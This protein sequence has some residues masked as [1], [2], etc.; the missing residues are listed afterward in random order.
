M[1]ADQ[2]SVDD[3]A[4]LNRVEL[5][6]AQA[7]FC[8]WLTFTVLGMGVAGMAY[9][10]SD[11][12]S[13]VSVFVW[14]LLALGL[15]TGILGII[16]GWPSATI[17][18]AVLR[19][20]VTVLMQMILVQVGV[21]AVMGVLFLDTNHEELGTMLATTFFVWAVGALYYVLLIPLRAKL[22][23]ERHPVAH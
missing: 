9:S 3:H 4:T 10:L 2:S 5:R 1:T 22:T 18:A 11:V 8:L 14:P 6:I 16:Y 15:L 13:G 7:G 23:D 21:G 19:R 20:R 17:P 12:P